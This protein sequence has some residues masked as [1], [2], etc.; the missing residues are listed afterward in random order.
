MKPREIYPAKI[1]QIEKIHA[2]RFE[3]WT[4]LD[5]GFAIAPAFGVSNTPVL[6][7]Q[8]MVLETLHLLLVKVQLLELSQ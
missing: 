4:S 8:V 3:C 5:R 1:K 7:L 6:G 2:T